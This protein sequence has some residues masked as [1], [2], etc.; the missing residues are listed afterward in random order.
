V[1]HALLPKIVAAIPASQ[2]K[3]KPY[4]AKHAG[5]VK[6]WGAAAHTAVHDAVKPA[7]KPAHVST[8][9]ASPVHDS[10][11][12]VR[13]AVRA[14]VK[15][16]LPKK[17]SKRSRKAMRRLP[18][19]VTRR[20]GEIAYNSAPGGTPPRPSSKG[21][22]PPGITE[23]GDK[24]D[25][26]DTQDFRVEPGLAYGH[27][28]KHTTVADQKA[29]DEARRLEEEERERQAAALKEQRKMEQDEPSKGA[30]QRRM[31]HEVEELEKDIAEETKSESLAYML[32]GVKMDLYQLHEQMDMLQKDVGN[33]VPLE[34]A[35][36]DEALVYPLSACMKCIFL[37]SAQYFILYTA[38]AIC[39]VFVDIFVQTEYQY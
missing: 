24:D 14:A 10:H 4:A 22:A 9:P 26:D 15:E 6:H 29:L 18:E 37:L 8:H 23:A 2:N 31:L 39:K 16:V 30:K 12:T 38:V 5:K 32:G 34:P 3:R 28:E 25:F 33:G 20:V 35:G 21:A 27:G 11:S 36:I 19:D 7:L 1:H 17:P 13:A